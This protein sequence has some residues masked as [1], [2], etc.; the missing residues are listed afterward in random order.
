MKIS[1]CIKIISFSIIL[2]FGGVSSANAADEGPSNSVLI[3]P[4]FV[5]GLASRLVQGISRNPSLSEQLSC[6]AVASY[7]AALETRCHLGSKSC[8]ADAEERADLYAADLASC[9]A[10][11]E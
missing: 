7:K 9:F 11:S 8:L 4:Q 2:G 1:N 10:V 6:V 3:G 5:D